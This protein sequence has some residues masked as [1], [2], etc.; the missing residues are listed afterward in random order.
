MGSADDLLLAMA[1]AQEAF[2]GVP[3]Q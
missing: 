2:D 1:A 3:D